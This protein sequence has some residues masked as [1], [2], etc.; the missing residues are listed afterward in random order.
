MTGGELA[1]IGGVGAV[2]AIFISSGGKIKNLF[3]SLQTIWLQSITLDKLLS[4]AIYRYCSDNMSMLPLRGK[5]YAGYKGNLKEKMEDQFFAFEILSHN[6]IVFRDGW[7]VLLI[8]PGKWLFDQQTGTYEKSVALDLPRFMWRPKQ[9]IDNALNHY[10]KITRGNL[11]SS[12]FGITRFHG[13]SKAAPTL[14]LDDGKK[15]DPA[16]GTSTHLL[17]EARLGRAK[18]VSYSLSNLFQDEDRSPFDWYA[19]PPYVLE[20]VERARKWYSSRRWYQI[21]RIPWKRG[22]L[23]CGGPGTGKSLLL[24]CVAQD[25]DMPIFLF[26]LPS[27]SNEEF[28]D[29]WEQA[30]LHT[31][32]MI[33]FEDFDSVFDGRKNITKT[34]EP[35]TFDCLLNCIS[36]VI[37]FDGIFLS[38]TTNNGNI[39]DPALSGTLNGEATRPGRIDETILLG[40][41]TVECR[42][43]M[44]RKILDD[45]SD[46]DTESVISSTDGKTAAQFIEVCNQMALNN[47]GFSKNGG[48]GNTNTKQSRKTI[49][50]SVASKVLNRS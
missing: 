10:S 23:V 7:R 13:K 3:M 38:I 33:L 42:R 35:L 25:L 8:G 2:L 21:K 37:A 31:P 34:T 9:F 18:L 39:I 41:M 6:R 44:V 28:V 47:K 45:L 1:T 5:V 14:C 43:K 50:G 27:M 15:S 32:C 49:S 16:L 26:D 12:R 29:F 20:A 17:R 11:V 19:Y 22:W 24:K 30:S 40:A 46:S 48:N 4:S 36:G